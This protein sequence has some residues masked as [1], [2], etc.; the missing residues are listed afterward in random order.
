M[1]R[2]AVTA[3]PSA[4]VGTIRRVMEEHGFGLL[5][6]AAEDG[7]LR[8]FVTRASLRGVAD[9]EVAVETVSHPVRFA[10]QPT[11]TL[12]KAA[13]IMLDNRL[14][15]LPVVEGDRL[16]GVITQSEVLRG[17]A[18][19]L[20]IGLVGTRM[21]IK[22]RKDSDDLFRTFDVL[23]EHGVHIVSLASRKENETHRDVVLRL[24]GI[25]DP[26]ALRLALEARLREDAEPP[27]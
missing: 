25:A 10:V 4:T 9:G 19:G 13:L 6:I 24:Q 26:E 14:V 2:E 21:E 20:G 15:L 23:R 3:L 5:L 1:Q 12:E 22:L 18:D 8:G 11:D 27:A 17:L 7:S 16:V